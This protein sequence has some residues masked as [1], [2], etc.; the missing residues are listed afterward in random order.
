MKDYTDYIASLENAGE[1]LTWDEWHDWIK[2]E[3]D[4]LAMQ[5]EDCEFITDT[6]I[7]DIIEILDND[8]YVRKTWYAIMDGTI[9]D[10]D[11]ETGSYDLQDAKRKCREFNDFNENED[12]GRYWYIAVIENDTCIKE[13]D[14]N[15]DER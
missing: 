5:N 12:G 1:K 8:E 15:G 11:W 10:N 2:K 7:N 9:D 3:N 13:L 4:D 14:E 6:E